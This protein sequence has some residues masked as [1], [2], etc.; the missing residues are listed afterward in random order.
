MLRSYLR[1]YFVYM[2]CKMLCNC[3]SSSFS[4][5]AI[6]I[7]NIGEFGAKNVFTD[8]RTA[9]TMHGFRDSFSVLNS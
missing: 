6:L 9:N 7:R 2:K 1:F 4:D 8:P 5:S 3:L